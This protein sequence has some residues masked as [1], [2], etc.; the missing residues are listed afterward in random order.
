LVF[1]N[2][3]DATLDMTSVI[4]VA[5]LDASSAAETAQKATAAQNLYKFRFD[6]ER[7]VQARR[8]PMPGLGKG[9]VL[10]DDYAPADGVDA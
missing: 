6:V 9:E 10:T 8:I 3:G 1:F 5:S 2:S 4:V 7:L